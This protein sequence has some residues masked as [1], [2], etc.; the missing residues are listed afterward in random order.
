MKYTFVC[1]H[2]FSPSTSGLEPLFLQLMY[3]SPWASFIHLKIFLWQASVYKM[4]HVFTCKPVFDCVCLC[5]VPQPVHCSVQDHLAGSNM[6]IEEHSVT[7]CS[8]VWVPP[9]CNLCLISF[10]T[11]VCV[12]VC[13]CVYLALW[14]LLSGLD[15]KRRCFVSGSR[16]ENPHRCRVTC[17]CYY[18]PSVSFQH[19]YK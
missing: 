2:I 18:F 17:L 6:L 19:S 1:Q 12:Y 7:G 3:L 13:F 4:I 16:L 8:V 10:K 9:Y 11:R 15:I 5:V 14:A